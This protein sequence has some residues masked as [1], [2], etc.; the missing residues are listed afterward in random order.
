MDNISDP[1]DYQSSDEYADREETQDSEMK[2]VEINNLL[3]EICQKVEDVRKMT[4]IINMA[5]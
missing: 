1:S 4:K 3:D 2:W 5:K